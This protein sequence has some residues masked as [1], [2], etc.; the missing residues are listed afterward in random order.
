MRRVPRRFRGSAAV[1]PFGTAVDGLVGELPGDVSYLGRD[2]DTRIAGFNNA[3]GVETPN[4]PPRSLCDAVVS[5]WWT[6]F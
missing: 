4:K 2:V 3:R 5:K 1:G 6:A